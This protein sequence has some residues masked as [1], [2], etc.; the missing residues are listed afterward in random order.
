MS[1]LNWDGSLTNMTDGWPLSNMSPGSG[2]PL[3]EYALLESMNKCGL[4]FLY[5]ISDRLGDDTIYELSVKDVMGMDIKVHVMNQKSFDILHE[6]LLQ[7]SLMV[8]SMNSFTEKAD[9]HLRSMMR[10]NH[11]S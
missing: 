8:L 10:V 2:R 3:T 7:R 1:F 9:E 4:L 11:G 5:R 6:S